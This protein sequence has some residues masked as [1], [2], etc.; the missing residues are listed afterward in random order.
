MYFI[1]SYLP[2]CGERW[3]DGDDSLGFVRYLVTEEGLEYEFIPLDRRS[4][5]EGYGPGG[6]PLPPLRDYSIA[7]ESGGESDW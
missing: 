1:Y 4:T 2:Q 3:P 6:H 5:A 7:W